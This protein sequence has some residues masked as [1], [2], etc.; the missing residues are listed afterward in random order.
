MP[1]ILLLLAW[2]DGITLRTDALFSM[3]SIDVEITLNSC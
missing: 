2:E 1:F 3:L